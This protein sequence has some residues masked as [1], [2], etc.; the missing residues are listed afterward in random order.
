MNKWG[1]L[2]ILFEIHLD[3]NVYYDNNIIQILNKMFK[4]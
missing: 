2:I 3:I 1:K 4:F